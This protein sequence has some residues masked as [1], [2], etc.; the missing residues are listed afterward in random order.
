MHIACKL[1]VLFFRQI[2]QTFCLLQPFKLK[3]EIGIQVLSLMYDCFIMLETSP[4]LCS[5]ICRIADE[6]NNQLEITK[7]PANLYHD[8]LDQLVVGNPS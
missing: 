2:Y 4:G 6:D 7:F 5:S 1:P 3:L 8:T